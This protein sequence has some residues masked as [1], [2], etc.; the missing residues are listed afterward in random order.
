[1]TWLTRNWGLKMVSFFLAV[2]LWY[3]ATG[4]EGIE[5]TRYVPVEVKVNNS[6]MSIL[7][8]SVPSVQVTFMA[9]RAMLSDLMSE[10]IKAYHEIGTEVKKAGEY[11]F[12]IEAGEIKLKTPQ[13]RIV[14]IEP[15]VLDVTL[16][17]LIVQ[18]VAIKP[19]F[20]GEPAFGYKVDTDKIE[21][22]PNAAMLEG[23]KGQLEKLQSIKTEKVDLVGRI[24][25][26]RRTLNLEIPANIKILSEDVVDLYVPIQEAYDEKEFKDIPVKVLL[27]AGKQEAEFK[28]EKVVVTLKGPR[29][30]FEGLGPDKITAYVDASNLQE[31]E[32][33]VEAQVILPEGLSL[34]A[35]KISVKILIKK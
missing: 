29:K 30:E 34:K 22:N 17:E 12:R 5:V 8:M 11:S 32:H 23:P 20:L 31:G 19:N 4:E 3:Y 21:M 9:P 27:P 2:G 6:Q 1:M 13:I 16:D 7:K 33:N 35:D 15:E 10:E 24:R 18:K 14:K 25:P 26:F 28:P